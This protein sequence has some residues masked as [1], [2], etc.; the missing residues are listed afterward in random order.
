MLLIGLSSVPSQ[1]TNGPLVLLLLTVVY[2]NRCWRQKTRRVETASSSVVLLTVFL[3]LQNFFI[4]NFSWHI[5]Y[6]Y[7]FISCTNCTV[8]DMCVKLLHLKG[9]SVMVS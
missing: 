6:L 4:F 1:V 2:Y 5:L 9:A 8:H 3:Y 7:L